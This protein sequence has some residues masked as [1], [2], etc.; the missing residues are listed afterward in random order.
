VAKTILCNSGFEAV[1]AA[2]KTAFLATGKPKVLAF[3]GAYHG[4][5]YGTL[6]VTERQHF[7]AAF[8]AQI[9]QFGNF[10][11]FPADAESL[12]SISLAVR[13]NLRGDVGAVLV[14]PVQV[15]GGV[16]VPPDM[17]LPQLRKLCDEFGALLILDEIYTGFGR[18]GR[19]FACEHSATVPDLICVGKALTGG[20]PMS[21]CIGRAD[22]MDTAWPVA[23]GDPIHTS[24]FLGNPVGCAMALAQI[25]QLELLKLVSNSAVLG[26]YLL[27]TL[28]EIEIPGLRLSARGLGL[29][30]GLEIR[31]PDSSPASGRAF[32]VVKRMLDRGF[33]VLPDGEYANVIEFTP[34]LT[35]KQRELARAVRALTETLEELK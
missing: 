13:K 2:M 35:I 29:L 23:T 28:S 22:L 10:V 32:Q 6:N 17:F 3:R 4:L 33:I 18:T 21:A 20:F 30:A 8:R 19:W 14:E 7:R 25:K 34:P 24:T 15:R 31:L 5:G 12:E 9:K 27:R 16:N 11:R 26:K 1:E